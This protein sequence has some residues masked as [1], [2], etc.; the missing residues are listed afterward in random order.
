MHGTVN[1]ECARQ[2]LKIGM[3]D[4]S[5]HIFQDESGNEFHFDAVEISLLGHVYI[6]RISGGFSVQHTLIVEAAERLK[7]DIY[8][9]ELQVVFSIEFLNDVDFHDIPRLHSRSAQS[10]E[11]NPTF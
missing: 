9:E 4:P 10:W 6:G 2:L 1:V 11:V 7:E 5:S 3:L 8:S